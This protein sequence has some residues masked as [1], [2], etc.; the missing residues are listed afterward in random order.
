MKKMMEALRYSLDG[1]GVRVELLLAGG[2]VRFYKD[3]G[4][5]GAQLLVLTVSVCT[6]RTLQ[7]RCTSSCTAWWVSA[8]GR[9]A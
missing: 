7:F 9:S 3:N 4:T 6:V 5:L 2:G 8:A 1:V